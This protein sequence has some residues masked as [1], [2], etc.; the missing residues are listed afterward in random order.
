MNQISIFAQNPYFQ[1]KISTKI[2]KIMLKP[3]FPIPEPRRCAKSGCQR[4]SEHYGDEK[5]ETATRQQA[6][7]RRNH[8]IVIL[9][10]KMHQQLIF[11]S[12]GQSEYTALA[13]IEAAAKIG[14]E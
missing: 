11:F 4:K 6:S 14:L 2:Q 8:E 10:L 1:L 13:D 3:H 9:I 12:P 7:I 5:T